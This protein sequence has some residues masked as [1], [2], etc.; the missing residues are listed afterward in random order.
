MRSYRLF[1]IAGVDVGVHPSWLVVFGLVTWSLATQ[2]YPD[3]RVLTDRDPT[4]HW[5]LGA[6]SAVLL[7]AAV[8]VHELAH[9]LVARAQGLDARSIT[10]FIFGGVSNLG[11]ESPRP[12]VEFLTA[13][14]GP[15]SS[16]LL[17][18]LAFL[19]AVA[20]PR[21]SAPEA[22]LSYLATINVLLGAFNLIPGFPLDGGRVLR[23]IV[24][25][26]TGSLRRSTEVAATAGTLVA[27]G[28]FIWGFVRVMD[29]DLLGGLWIA[30]I[31]W[32][33]QS[34]AGASVQQVRIDEALRG[35]RVGDILRRDETTVSP[36][37]TV[38][39]LIEQHFLP[40]NRRAIPVAEDGRLVGIATL[41][42]IKDVPPERRAT[43]TVASEMGGRDGLVTIGPLASLSQA[44]EA[45]GRGDY[46]QVPVVDGG[47]YLGML[48]RGDVLRQFQ[49]RAELGLG[50]E[51]GSGDG[52]A[53]TAAPTG[54]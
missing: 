30:A 48:S 47:R 14:V 11:G 35:T 13:I 26:A 38:A 54:S 34:A 23:S 43:T 10:L 7:F 51:S 49:L 2:Y 45:L 44:L 28:F 33:L 9:S 41:G 25:Q 32:F 18:G 53:R 27:Y 50:A 12:R 37:T 19:G 24:W 8:L 15:L 17:G 42:D 29:G 16:F 5:V 46:E 36:T 3:P 21:G 52:T 1:R 31:G 39:E 6:I 4:L 22:V 40:R 20:A